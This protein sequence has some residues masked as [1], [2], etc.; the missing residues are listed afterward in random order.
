MNGL[1]LLIAGVCDW[2]NHPEVAATRWEVMSLVLL[3]MVLLILIL[4]ISGVW[5]SHEGN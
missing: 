5:H 4:G 2:L 1:S 3:G